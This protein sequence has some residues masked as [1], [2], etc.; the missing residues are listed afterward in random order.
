M[1]AP[2]SVL[3]PTLNA[4]AGLPGCLAALMPGLAAGLIAELIVSDGGSA[5]A[6]VVIAG[7]A[8]ARI[9]AG[10]A[11]R[12]GQLRR[13]AAAA[14]GDWLLVVHADTRLGPG[15]AD[16]AARHMATRPDR[17]GYFRLRF[18]AAGPGPRIVAGWGNARSRA[19][20]LPFGD[21]GLLIPRGLYD[22]TG[23]YP[24]IP[25]MEDLALAR[26]LRG[27]LAAIDAEAATGFARYRARGWVRQG[28]ANLWRQARFLAGADPAALARGYARGTPGAR[29]AGGRGR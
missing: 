14:R 15:W 3:I 21:Q 26:A 12:G 8:G 5:D 22:A 9:V 2:V 18:D 16:A 25:L 23:G 17:A 6:T 10:P 11:G 24:D 20:D 1:P 19:L 27:R 28:A 7:T 29:R 13:G 4:A